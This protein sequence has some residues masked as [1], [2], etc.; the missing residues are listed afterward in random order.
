MRIATD[1]LATAAAAATTVAAVA[2]VGAYAPLLVSGVATIVQIALERAS[3]IVCQAAARRRAAQLAPGAVA[4]TAVQAAAPRA[5]VRGADAC[6]SAALAVQAA[7][8]AATGHVQR[9]RVS[10]AAATGCRRRRAGVRRWQ[11]GGRWWR[12]RR[13][14]AGGEAA[15]VELRV[16]QA[17]A[18]AVQAARA[19]PP[20]RARGVRRAA[21]SSRRRVRLAAQCTLPRRRW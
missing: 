5:A 9:V 20:S 8:R 16:M 4:A 2:R 7:R 14:G 11:L 6:R 13:C 21:V 12:R 19:L 1:D 15:R 10:V 18:T 17:A 3:A